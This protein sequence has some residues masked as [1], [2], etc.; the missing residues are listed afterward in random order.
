MNDIQMQLEIHK[1][2]QKLRVRICKAKKK[3]YEDFIDY[4]ANEL[5]FYAYLRNIHSIS[6]RFYDRF[7]YEITSALIKTK[8]IKWSKDDLTT[9]CEI[10]QLRKKIEKKMKKEE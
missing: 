3:D 10:R 8:H 4:M 2:M 5:E 9:Y 6:G 7:F 1:R